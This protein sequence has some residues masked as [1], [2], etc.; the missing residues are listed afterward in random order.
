LSKRINISLYA[1]FKD[2]KKKKDKYCP[3][4]INHP[5]K[6]KK[7]KDFRGIYKTSIWDNVCLMWVSIPNRT[8]GLGI[9][10]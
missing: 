5:L 10:K 6:E 3:S 9:I 7:G 8:E 1:D 2:Q 4:T